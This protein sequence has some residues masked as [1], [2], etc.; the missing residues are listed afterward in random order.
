MKRLSFFIVL[1]VM[2]VVSMA[3]AEDWYEA[4][5]SSHYDY[6]DVVGI[7][8][9]S[10][11]PKASEHVPKD[12]ID[13]AT[14]KNGK[15]D[16]REND[17]MSEVTRISRRERQGAQRERISRTERQV[18]QRE[19]SATRRISAKRLGV[20]DDVVSSSPAFG[21]QKKKEMRLRKR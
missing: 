11:S 2:G 13:A 15:K 19:M 20:R 5:E 1:M 16:L 21:E 6:A 10:E 7:Q 9:Q 12:G 4:E 3:S 18:A 14:S 8:I 17:R